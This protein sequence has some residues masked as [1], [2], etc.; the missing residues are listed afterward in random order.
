MTKTTSSSNIVNLISQRRFRDEH[1]KW[2]GFITEDNHLIQKIFDRDGVEYN[3]ILHEN[4]TV[5]DGFAVLDSPETFER[6]TEAAKPV[7]SKRVGRWHQTLHWNRE[8]SEF[9]CYK[10]NDFPGVMMIESVPVEDVSRWLLDIDEEQ[11]VDFSETG[12]LAISL[13]TELREQI[14]RVASVEH[15]SVRDWIID[16]LSECIGD[17]RSVVSLAKAEFALQR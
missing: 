12:H 5:D 10:T 15:R 16:R 17:E 4:G 11:T 2:V 1:L 13:P 14:A 3:G 9:F 8:T 7:A 6:L